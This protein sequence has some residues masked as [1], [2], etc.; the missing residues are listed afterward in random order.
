MGVQAISEI[1]SVRRFPGVS[2]SCHRLLRVVDILHL[3]GEN[4]EACRR[5]RGR[6]L[7]GSLAES[8]ARGL[9]RRQGRWP[10]SR[11]GARRATATAT[12]QC[13]Q[14]TVI[15]ADPSG[16]RPER[17]PRTSNPRSRRTRN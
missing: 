2:C 15:P 5:N 13:E 6:C 14:W 11:E 1:D 9:A 17:K 12:L 10:A 8:A 7:I 3:C 16:A 4:E